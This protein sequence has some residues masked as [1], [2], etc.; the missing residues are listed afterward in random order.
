MSV[1]QRPRGSGQWVSKFQW[2][3]N[4]HWTPGG[5]WATKSAALEAERRHRDQLARRRTSEARHCG[6]LRFVH[7]GYAPEMRA[8]IVFTAWTGLRASEVAGLQWQDVGTNT[9][10]VRRA[11]KDDGSY[12]KPK[13]GRER[14]IAF[15]VLARVLDQVPRRDPCTTSGTRCAN[16]SGTS[17]GNKLVAD[18]AGTP[19]GGRP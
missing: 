19:M 1:F 17:V 3:G 18:G 6:R 14:E 5:P 12:G 10:R 2:R 11:R 7:G 16:S 15:P 9:L 13:N 8:L 4:Q